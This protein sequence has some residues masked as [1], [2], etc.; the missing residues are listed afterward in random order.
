MK[1]YYIHQQQLL[2][3]HN[4]Q[5]CI[6]RVSIGNRLLNYLA[7]FFATLFSITILT[8]PASAQ[9][10][11]W[12]W[13]NPLPQGNALSDVQMI[14][15]DHVVAVG[16]AGTFMFTTNGGV[17][18]QV[19]YHLNG[20]TSLGG[21]SFI[22]KDTGTVVGYSYDGSTYNGI[23]LRTTNGGKLWNNQTIPSAQILSG[24]HFTDANT[25]TVVGSHYPSDS[26]VIL[27]TTNGGETW[28]KQNIGTLGRLV[29]VF[30]RGSDT[31]T[32]VGRYGRILHTTD[33][34]TTWVAQNSGTGVYL[35]DV[36]FINADTGTIVGRSGT[37]IHTTNGGTSWTSQTSGTSKDLNSVSFTD[38]DR[39][40][41]VGSN[42]L[43]L[44]T[45][46][47]GSTWTTQTSETTPYFYYLLGVSFVNSDTGTAVG[48]GGIILR[49]T[50]GGN[51][52]IN[53]NKG[54][55][56]DFYGIDFPSAMKGTVVGDRGMMLR[57]TN[58]G[59]TWIQQA[60]GTVQLLTSVSFGDTNAG[61]AVGSSGIIIHTTDGGNSWV[62]QT[63]GTS[64]YLS[65]V[66][67]TVPDTGTAIGTGGTI[68]HTND[69]G[70]TWTSQTSGTLSDLYGISFTDVNTGTVVGSG[71]TILRTIDGGSTW[72]NQ[73]SGTTD[74]LFAV[75]F[76]DSNT[77]T[78]VGNDWATLG[79]S[80]FLRTTDGGN[81]W[82]RQNSDVDQ[83]LFTVSFAD[84][85]IGVASGYWGPF[86][87]LLTTDGG[88]T[89]NEWATPGGYPNSFSFVKNKVA[90]GWEL[91]SA[92]YSG[93]VQ[94]AS[95]QPL[96]GKVW[97][98]AIDSSWDTP[99]NW[100]PIGVPT[101]G[102]S[103]VIPP[104]SI[105]PVVYEQQ[106]QITL[107]WLTILAGGKL[108]LTPALGRLA[109]K[110]DLEVNGTLE[111]RS[112]AATSIVEGRNWII[113]PTGEYDDG[114][115]PGN[116]TVYFEGT[117][118]FSGDFY[119]T[120]IDV[121]SEMTSRGNVTVKNQ[122]T[123]LKEFQ[124][125]S[126]DTLSIENANSQAL[127]G[128]ES[129]ANGTVQ[130]SIAHGDTNI[131]RFHTP[132]TYVK[133]KSQSFG[134]SPSVLSFPSTVTVTVFPD[135]NPETFGTEW[136]LVP[137]NVDTITN[138]VTAD[139]I[140][141]FSKWRIAIPRPSGVIPSVRRV[142]SIKAIGGTDF[143][144]QLSL[145][146]EQSEIPPDIT[147]DSLQLWRLKSSVN[148]TITEGWNMLSL[149]LTVSDYSTTTLFPSSTSGAFAYQ[150]GYIL[151]DTLENG[152]AYWLKF[153]S[154]QT[155]SVIGHERT[156]ETIEVQNKWNMIGSITQPIA[157]T[158]I[159]SQPPGI[160]TSQFYEYES[161]YAVS[162]TIMP[163]KGYWVKVNQ[164][165]QLILS[166]NG[167][168]S[169]SNGIHIVP[170]SELP[171]SPPDARVSEFKSIPGSYELEQNYPNPF[172]PLT[173]IRYQLPVESKVTLR[174][175]NVLGHL[176]AT[177]LDETQ[178]AGYK[179]AEWN[180]ISNAS[181]IYFL[182]ID[183]VS[184]INPGQ[185]FMQMRKLLFMK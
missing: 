150:G 55:S 118:S 16:D 9:V 7:F 110:V 180:A 49:T 142:F 167:L 173:V 20:A 159:I 85:N 41:A 113:E 93:T 169:A 116:S 64:S 31:G 112:N 156:D 25:G 179:S 162:D 76:T 32:A 78:I 72:T 134:K 86:I 36:V 58:G 140:T 174:I 154:A 146:Y 34:G 161:G 111:V 135:T 2:R 59:Q 124:L 149:P 91:Y 101:P 71:G 79:S 52:W 51:N 40:T 83:W 131:Y 11:S 148:T 54:P 158:H 182:R 81:T 108:T 77:G 129:I 119:N 80:F 151:K 98:G 45:T 57:T 84:A 8:M 128:Q 125:Q 63:S 132:N 99:G 133:F 97:T 109:L 171:P 22:N 27:R 145:Q 13:L 47:G 5:I 147:E 114:F 17:T 69:G 53:Q 120:V 184:S 6:Q 143:F 183:A 163:G 46:N 87:I 130:R 43:I 95:I 105:N 28:T 92:G 33:G 121:T 126:T 139:N 170:I 56:S 65:G 96:S 68:I 166:S 157:V 24:V 122:C 62:S 165:G 181:G 60:T 14:D 123:V 21:V 42:D 160:V 66:S 90:S 4:L 115:H 155:L 61:T 168:M 152:R 3:S 176:V 1:Q 39:G 67:F 172:N 38:T 23:I 136:E 89:W 178:D 70:A 117:G 94:H 100:S 73:T 30:F 18:W 141:E 164:D 185:S 19:S 107:G 44:H 29:D 12:Q 138:T 26:S 15:A 74:Y 153:S 10:S 104:T 106:Q 37:I 177:L 102:D 48:S 82:I 137:S 103:V 144:A 88:T 175:Y 75:S 50:N 127:I 35:N